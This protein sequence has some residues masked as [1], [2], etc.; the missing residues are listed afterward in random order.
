MQPSLLAKR[1]WF[2]LFFAIGA[3][4]LW[5]L[6]S[7]P[8][9][10]PDEPRY[11]QVA[12]EMLNRHDLIT[13]TLGGLPW[14][15]KP[16][17]LYWLII[18]S[19]RLFGVNEYATRLGPAIC[20]LLTAAFIY[21][22]ARRVSESNPREDDAGSLAR[23]SALVF[24]SSV[25]ALAF[26]RGASFDIVLT[27][28]VTG[29]LSFFFASDGG[30]TRSQAESIA[31]LLLFHVFTGLS[32]LAKGLIGYVIIYGTISLYCL[33][34]RR[35]PA[36]SFLKTL[37]WGIPLS[38]AVA[39]VWYGPMIARHG[40]T[41][42]DRFII[43]HH[44]Q[45]FASNKYHHPGPIYYYLPVVLALA[46]PWTIFLLKA[47]WAARRFDWRG[48]T[49]LNKLRVLGLAWLIVPVLFFS[50]SGSKLSAYIL[51]VLPAI[52]LLVGDRLMIYARSRATMDRAADLVLRVTGGLLLILTIAITL[53]AHRKFG[54][55][56]GPVILSLSAMA[57]I[58]IIAIVR[59]QLGRPLVLSIALG[60]IGTVAV[61]LHFFAPVVAREH[62]MRDP[63]ALA[64]SRGYANTPIV[65]LHTVERTSEFY[66]AGRIMYGPDGDV[67]WF[68]TV[69]EVVEAA[70]RNQGSVLCIVP[71][72]YQ[73]QVINNRQMQT[74]VIAD[75]GY[76]ALLGVRLR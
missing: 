48:E 14:F 61:M 52:A 7:L 66:G 21:W 8:L 22:T 3:F 10:G 16:P 28:T 24:L 13:P 50:F 2:L 43:Q 30:S 15:E 51:P 62:S 12:R 29:A 26:S 63:L 27:M 58:A 17:L 54:L 37:A 31:I 75:D 56:P 25:G 34:R 73:Y 76:L 35:W 6:G 39:S 74:E 9:V 1:A 36:R 40:W 4:Y 65:M 59:P 42:I 57:A 20:G 68:Q 53:A 32:L 5:G 18:L 49:A 69:A 46:I 44:F 67:V 71:V 33:L 23:W 38:V 47:L 55:S 70:R 60:T 41:F 11:A 72:E 45:R 64:A 19:Y